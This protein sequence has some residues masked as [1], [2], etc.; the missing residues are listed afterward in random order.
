M[1]SGSYAVYFTLGIFVNS[2]TA[3]ATPKS[4]PGHLLSWS[5]IGVLVLLMW[6]TFAA[7]L[8]SG[9]LGPGLGTVLLGL[10]LLTWGLCFFASYYY[11]HKSFFLRALMWYSEH[12][13]RG[14][15][16]MSFVY[17]ALCAGGGSVVILIGLGIL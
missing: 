7:G 1:R 8:K 15:R 12:T 14:S 5:L 3:Q 10:Y 2:A 16:R 4:E 6:A 11:S 9:S 17:F 13:G